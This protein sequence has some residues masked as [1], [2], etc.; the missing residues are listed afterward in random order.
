[1]RNL[2]PLRPLLLLLVLVVARSP[3]PAQTTSA[4]AHVQ[5]IRKTTNLFHVGE[6]I[7]VTQYGQPKSTGVF[8]EVAN[9]QLVYTETATGATQHIPLNQVRSVHEIRTGHHIAIAIYVG[10]VVTAGVATALAL[11]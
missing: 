9:A 5:K 11:R 4:D 1:M 7:A 2:I 3:V 8:Q 6:K 10:L